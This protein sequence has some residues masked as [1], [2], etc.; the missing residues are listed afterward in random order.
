M[1]NGRLF[2]GIDP[3]VGGGMAVIDE[4]VDHDLQD[5]VGITCLKF[6]DATEADI[7]NFVLSSVTTSDCEKFALIEK[8]SSSP[9]MGV[10]SAFTFGR[11]YG[12]LRGMLI[13]HGIPFEEVRPQLWQKSLGCLTKGDKNISK[14]RAQQLFPAEKITHAN[15][16]AILIA[17]H[18]RRTHPGRG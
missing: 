6:K 2:V 3:G 1:A 17:E 15:A 13:A 4:F 11:S 9:Q 14:A 12:F 8:V 10:V 5:R 16:D 18:C 7:S